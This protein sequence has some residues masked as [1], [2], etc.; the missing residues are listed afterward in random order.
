MECL[1]L[2]AYMNKPPGQVGQASGHVKI[3]PAWALV[4]SFDAFLLETSM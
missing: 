4:T 1:V 2:G 3:I